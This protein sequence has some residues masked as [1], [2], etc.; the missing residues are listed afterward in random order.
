M[1]GIRLP[2]HDAIALGLF[3]HSDGLAKRLQ[4]PDNV[5][6]YWCIGHRSLLGVKRHKPIAHE[7]A[8]AQ[9]VSSYA[10]NG[11]T[12]HEHHVMLTYQ[13]S[14]ITFV[15]CTVL[16]TAECHECRCEKLPTRAQMDVAGH[17]NRRCSFTT[18]L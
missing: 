12:L 15:Q 3:L 13:H 5:S 6:A 18:V 17:A 4:W 1:L 9:S 11:R 16:N 10:S 14:N 7:G 8:G 2:L